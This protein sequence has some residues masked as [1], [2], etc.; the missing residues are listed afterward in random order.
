MYVGCCEGDGEG[1][2]FLGRRFQA[3]AHE[4]HGDGSSASG[5]GAGA[6]SERAGGRTS[7]S[8]TQWRMASESFGR[9]SGIGFVFRAAVAAF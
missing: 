2:G 3:E 1:Q 9:E 6:S 5:A 8:P 7:P 4:P